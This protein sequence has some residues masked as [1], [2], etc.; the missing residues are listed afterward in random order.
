MP[1]KEENLYRRG[2]T[3]YGRVS[4]AN[5]DYRCSLRTDDL[6]EAKIRLKE[7]IKRTERQALGYKQNTPTFRAAALKWEEEVLPKNVKRQVVRRYLTSLVS[8]EKIMGVVPVDQ[9]DGPLISEYISSRQAVVTNATLR[10]DLTALSSLLSAC[11]SWGWISENAANR[12]DRRIIKERRK[13][14]KLVRRRDYLA[15]IG[16]LPPPMASLLHFLDQSGVRLDEAVSL[17]GWQINNPAA[18]QI[19]LDKTKTDRPRVLP[20]VTPAGD[21]SALI[22]KKPPKGFLFVNRDGQP[23]SNFSS[24]FGQVARRLGMRARL[25]KTDFQRFRVHDLR[26][27]FAIRWLQNGG[28]IYRL[29]K[30][31][32][33]T[34]VKTT[35]IY[36]DYVEQSVQE[37]AKFGEKGV[38]SGLAQP[39]AQAKKRGRKD[40]ETVENNEGI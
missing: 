12:F 28:D 31:L 27:M 36:L 24:N 35:E 32:G 37:R 22:P 26:H 38:F 19:F 16:E 8:L 23:Y 10:R 4:V 21:L 1:R 39:A 7:W 25:E 17:E 14:I 34:S 20:F 11:C 3:W 30:H 2:D 33:H 40:T 6:R 13:P 9:I 18:G 29:S 5:R 15:V